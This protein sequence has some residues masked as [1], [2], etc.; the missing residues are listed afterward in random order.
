MQPLGHPWDDLDVHA[1]HTCD[2][3]LNIAEKRLRGAADRRVIEIPDD[4]FIPYPL[5]IRSNA[6][7]NRIWSFGTPFWSTRL[8]NDRS[9]D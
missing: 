9:N 8:S 3:P 6:S 2:A 4:K 1:H 5:A 7:A